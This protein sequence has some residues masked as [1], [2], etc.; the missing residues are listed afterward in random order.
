MKLTRVQNIRGFQNPHAVEAKRL[1]DTDNA[2]V[3]HMA[4]KPGQSLKKHVT[5]V[6][7]FFYI[8]EG[9]GTVEIGDEKQEVEKDML[10]ESPK[11]S[12]HLLSNTG[13]GIFRFLA[14][15]VPKQKEP[16]KFL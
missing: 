6:D 3:I 2:E 8:L 16:T 13:E 5:P 1:Y 12:P 7:V 10:I 14:V 9:K 15:K 4:L 11:N